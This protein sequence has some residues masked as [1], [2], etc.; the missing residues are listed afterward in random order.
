MTNIHI[1]TPLIE[2]LSIGKK[3]HAKVWLKVDA[4]QPCGSFKARGIGYACQKYVENGA[5]ALVS[6]ACI[7]LHCRDFFRITGLRLSCH[8]RS[9]PGKP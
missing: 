9:R 8:L 1:N 4:L 5:Q 6:S 2:S 3:L 7:L